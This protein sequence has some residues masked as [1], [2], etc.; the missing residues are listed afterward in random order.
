[1]ADFHFIT[2]PTALQIISTILNAAGPNFN[3]PY[4]SSTQPSDATGRNDDLLTQFDLPAGVSIRGTANTSMLPNMGPVINSLLTA[5]GPAISAY[6]FI[7]PI[8]G[9]IRG[10]MEIMCCLMNPFCV[11][12]A[13]IRLFKKW[14]PPFLSLFPPIAGVIMIISTIKLIL[15]IIFF[16]LTEVVPTIELIKKNVELVVDAFQSGNE[17]RAEAGKSKLIALIIDLANRSGITSVAKPI[18][19][20]LFL[21]LGLVS[22]LPCSGGRNSSE[23]LGSI[24][25]GV[26]TFDG[27]ELDTACCDDTQCPPVIA[28]PPQGRGLLVPKFFGDAP[29][30]FTW[31]L[32]P[33]TGQENMNDII[34]FLQDFKS[35]LNPQL[36]EDIDEAT[37]AGSTNDAAHF[38]LRILGRRGER[39]CRE[40]SSGPVPSGSISAPIARIRNS[41]V[42]M[43]NVNLTKFMGVVDYC[44][45]PNFDQLVARNIIGIG[46]HP[47]VIDAKEGMQNRFDGF[48][49]LSALDKFPELVDIPDIYSGMTDGL[50]TA[51]GQLNDVVDKPVEDYSLDDISV[52]GGIGDGIVNLLLGVIDRFTEIMNSLLSNMTDKI[53]TSFDVDKNIVKAGNQDKAIVVVVPRDIS[54]TAIGKNLPDGVDI[55]VDFFTDFG[56]LRNQQRNNSTGEVTAELTSAF[57]GTA[58]VT[59][60]VN[61]DF[62]T[63]FDGETE[64]IKVEQVRFVAD[65]ILPKRRFVSKPTAD[66]KIKTNAGSEREPGSR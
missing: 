54:G 35:Q 16:I 17:T 30:L 40:D 20:L 45:E 60:R 38:K 39:F 29:P 33:I 5:L 47:D 15:A 58:N 31:Q 3:A 7:L 22:G 49:E 6:G 10:L 36:D 9:L 12:K 23:D 53:S 21:I 50:D 27:S 34:P 59:A 44:I 32:I 24:S 66:S 46:C 13:V 65:A 56:V 42:T 48:F 62:I 26:P 11:I 2:D 37:P 14:L 4:D 1:M 25:L 8:L 19:D 61:N 63:N 41:R 43:T 28:S 18:L 51:F 57:A 52:I 64:T 55:N